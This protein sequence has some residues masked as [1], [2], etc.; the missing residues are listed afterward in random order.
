M[1]MLRIWSHESFSVHILFDL[2]LMLVQADILY[3]STVSFF[4]L[5]DD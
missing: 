1:R 3:T 4:D 5:L 2:H